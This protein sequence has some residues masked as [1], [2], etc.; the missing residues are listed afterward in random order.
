MAGSNLP[1]LYT[2]AEECVLCCRALFFHPFARLYHQF[3]V[4][5]SAA[6]NGPC[7]FARK[8]VYVAHNFAAKEAWSVPDTTLISAERLSRSQRGSQLMAATN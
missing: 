1:N 8:Q 6:E 4:A 5:M 3:E 7:M 2:G